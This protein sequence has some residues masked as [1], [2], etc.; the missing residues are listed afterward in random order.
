MS[1]EDLRRHRDHHLSSSK[2]SVDSFGGN[3]RRT[4]SDTDLALQSL[5]K[6]V[7]VC[8]E[9]VL[10]HP[11]NKGHL[12]HIESV[13]YL[14]ALLTQRQCKCEAEPSVGPFSE[15]PPCN[16]CFILSV[17]VTYSRQYQIERQREETDKGEDQTHQTMQGKK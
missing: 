1:F 4:R 12:G 2:R 7:E 3:I 10:V 6:K 14:E 9:S 16:Q 15:V 17:A 5:K 8:G 11:L 13:L